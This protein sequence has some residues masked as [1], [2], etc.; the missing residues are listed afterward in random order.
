MPGRQG[1]ILVACDAEPRVE[2]LA[3]VQAEDSYAV[4]LRLPE[5]LRRRAVD[6]MARMLREDG[7]VV[8]L[9]ESSRDALKRLGRTAD[10]G[11]LLLDIGAP[12][13]GHA[14][15][16]CYARS[17]NP[18]LPIFVLSTCREC[19]KWQAAVPGPPPL[20]FTK[21]VEYADLRLEL[22]RVLRSHTG[23]MLRVVDTDPHVGASTANGDDERRR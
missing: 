23:Q 16:M 1:I 14:Q 18:I 4:A 17:L 8:S 9:T 13:D 15:T 11:A 10:L 19:D 3:S 6:V 21:P 7:F 2:L 12:N 5:T 20:F 22:G